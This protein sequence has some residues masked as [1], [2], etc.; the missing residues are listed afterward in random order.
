MA[1][2]VAEQKVCFTGGSSMSITDPNCGNQ[3]VLATVQQTTYRAGTTSAATGSADTTDGEY[4]KAR[5]EW[6]DCNS[7]ARSAELE[8]GKNVTP[9][10]DACPRP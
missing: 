5:L 10:G 3:G 4:C 6:V 9:S 2:I 7:D 1:C 8:G